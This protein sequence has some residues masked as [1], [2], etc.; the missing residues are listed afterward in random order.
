MRKKLTNE[1]E[2]WRPQLGNALRRYAEK[3]LRATN[4]GNLS[5]D[6]NVTDMARYFMAKGIEAVTG[7]AIPADVKELLA[8]FDLDFDV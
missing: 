8:R 7:R 3:S 2:N 6:W 1:D 4:N 5:R